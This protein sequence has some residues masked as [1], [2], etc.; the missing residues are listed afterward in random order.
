M[1]EPN[2]MCWRKHFGV[3][4]GACHHIDFIR[5]IIVVICKRCAAN[6]AKATRDVRRGMKL[7]RL[8]ARKLEP[9]NR[10]SDERQ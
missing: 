7:E 10:K 5:M 6:T 9:I 8:S 1:G 2:M 3:I 4:E